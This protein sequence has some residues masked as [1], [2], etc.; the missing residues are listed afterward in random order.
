MNT[1]PKPDLKHLTNRDKITQRDYRINQPELPPAKVDFKSAIA[2]LS[3]KLK[4]D[5]EMRLVWKENVAFAFLHKCIEFKKRNNKKQLSDDD[6]K[7]IAD[8]AAEYF[9]SQLVGDMK[10]PK[11]H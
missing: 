4:R 11:D 9:M 1:M 10:I 3:A 2:I 7:V 6:L 8:E 5:K